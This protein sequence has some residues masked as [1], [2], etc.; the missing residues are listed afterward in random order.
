MLAAH[1]S[2]FHF[3]HG[4]GPVKIEDALAGAVQLLAAFA[5]AGGQAV[6]A[7]FDTVIAPVA[8]FF[9]G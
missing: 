1:L 3:A 8:Q 4:Q 2:G 6:K 7:G 9:E 5:V